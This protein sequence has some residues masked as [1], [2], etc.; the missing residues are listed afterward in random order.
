LSKRNKTRQETFF[1]G[2]RD[3]QT[4]A[5][6]ASEPFASLNQLM[7]EAALRAR[8]QEMNALP[9]RP[10]KAALR[11]ADVQQAGRG[12][13]DAEKPALS[14]TAETPKTQEKKLFPGEKSSRK[15]RKISI[16]D[17]WVEIRMEAGAV[18]TTLYPSN[19]ALIE[20]GKKMDV[21]PE[22]VYRRLNFPDGVPDVYDWVLPEESASAANLKEHG[23]CGIQ[24]LTVDQW[25]KVIEEEKLRTDGHIG[26]TGVGNLPRP[27]ERG[28]CEC[29]SCT[30]AKQRV[31]A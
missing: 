25:L 20:E 18:T 22:M 4:F 29:P 8:L 7:N 15:K 11:S 23:G 27:E 16:L 5:E 3:A 9:L 13:G 26:G 1:N 30:R 17:Q 12:A 14:E 31:A 24:R 28:G 2:R 10:W 6:A 19:E 21:P